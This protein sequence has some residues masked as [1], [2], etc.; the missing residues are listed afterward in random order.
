MCKMCLV[1]T[2]MAM[3][4]DR[5]SKPTDANRPLA[6]VCKRSEHEEV[7]QIECFEFKIHTLSKS[8]Q[9]FEKIGKCET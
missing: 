7:F 6:A 3:N 4:I 8:D 1:C 5:S 9:Q 2:A